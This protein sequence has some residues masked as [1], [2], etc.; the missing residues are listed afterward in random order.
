MLTVHLVRSCSSTASTVRNEVELAALAGHAADI[1]GPPP[2]AA[3]GGQCGPL[4][5]MTRARGQPPWPQGLTFSVPGIASCAGVVLPLPVVSG[6]L[7]CAFIVPWL[8]AALGRCW[9][10]ETSAQAG[11]AAASAAPRATVRSTFA[12]Q[13][14]FR[15]RASG[16]LVLRAEARLGFQTLCSGQRRSAIDSVAG[17]TL[18]VA[19]ITGRSASV[20]NAQGQAPTI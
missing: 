13:A 20:V 19:P 9:V 18:G 17:I 14:S 2:G 4:R 16:R 15:M 10:V 5:V 8:Q 11:L 1:R 12:S 7:S 3:G 6:T